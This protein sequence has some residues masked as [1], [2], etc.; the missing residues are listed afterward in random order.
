M[1]TYER[2]DYGSPDGCQIGAAATDKIGL[3]GNTPIVQPSVTA[4]GTTAISQVGTS[5]K[6]AFA[7]ST[8]ALAFV[9]LVQSI[10]TKLDALGAVKKG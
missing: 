10:Q 1:S 8:A 9:S 7:T 3:Y 6:W 4:I 2:L 5:G